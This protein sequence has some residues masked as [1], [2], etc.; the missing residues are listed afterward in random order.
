MDTL[1]STDTG[2]PNDYA[3][4]LRDTQEDYLVL[5][6]ASA[7]FLVSV[8]VTG[9]VI[10]LIS[11]FAAVTTY[12]SDSEVHAFGALI[13][14]AKQ[15]LKGAMLTVAFVCV[16]KTAAVA[17]LLASSELVAF[18]AFRRY[19]RLFLA[20]CLVLLVAFAFYIFLSFFCSLA[21][22]VA[23]DES[24][25]RRCHGAGAVGRSWQLVK[26]RQER[27]MLFVSVMSVLASV[28]RLI[29]WQA[30]ICARSN[31][32]SGALLLGVLYTILVAALEL[33]QDCAMTAFYYE[34][35]GRSAQ[36]SETEYVKLSIQD[37]S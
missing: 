21:V 18:L 24:E 6:L 20:G 29:Y 10:Q 4:L 9:S 11:L 35:K 17:L 34:C 1:M 27:A 13:A 37:T 12:S 8:D 16:L 28:F 33:F 32:A 25:A 7:A 36:E 15:Q 23:V 30:K 2:G 14:K 19:C 3:R 31:M 5:L 26:G 22:V